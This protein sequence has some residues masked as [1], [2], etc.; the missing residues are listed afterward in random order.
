MPPLHCLHCKYNTNNKYDYKKH[1]HTIKHMRIASEI[2]S[3][4]IA[5]NSVSTV[6]TIEKKVSTIDD[7]VITNKYLNS[8]KLIHCEY[9][10]KSFPH[11]SSLSRHRNKYCNKNSIVV[12]KKD[13]ISKEKEL[14]LQERKIIEIERELIHKKE[15][16]LN[17]Q[18]QK[19]ESDNNPNQIQGN[20]NI[21]NNVGGNN[22]NINNNQIVVNNFPDADRSHITQEQYIDAFK[23]PVHMIPLL[24]EL[25]RFSKDKPENLNIKLQNK[26]NKEILTY[27][28]GSWED[29]GYSHTMR[30]A[31]DS[32]VDNIYIVAEQFKKNGI[33]KEKM[34][35]S[36]IKTFER[37]MDKYDTEWNISNANKPK[38]ETYDNVTGM[39]VYKLRKYSIK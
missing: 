29:H 18:R 4:I 33:M 34:L 22:N 24:F 30:E 37:F 28:D 2:N 38:K 11:K 21:N 13:N 16:Y 19:L 20:A 3:S 35:P 17:Y 10:G 27:A 6:S 31:A 32:E 25:T 1:L 23:K 9:C 26:K 5:V 15:E 36:E 7:I 39:I 14:I 12:L 8:D